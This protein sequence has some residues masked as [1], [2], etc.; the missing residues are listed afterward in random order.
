MAIQQ[1]QGHWRIKVAAGEF[2]P[3]DLQT[4]QDWV[5]QGRITPNDFVLSPVTNA[6][7][8]AMNVPEL[9]GLF[10]PG[11]PRGPFPPAPVKEKKGLNVGCIIAAAVA[12]FLALIFLA[13]MLVPALA[14]AREQARRAA[15]LSNLKQQ[16]LGLKQYAQDFSQMYPWCAGRQDPDEAWRDLGLMYPNYITAVGVYICPSSKDGR[17]EPMCDSGAKENYP[18][19]PFRSHPGECTS[20]A[21]S[22]ARGRRRVRPCGEED[23]STVRLLA[24]KKAGTEIGSANNDPTKANHKDD[25]RNVLYQDGH[26]KWQRGPDALDPDPE[27]DRIGWPS[28][29]DYADWW[30]DPPYYGERQQR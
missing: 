10:P 18:F 30:S 17:F 13:G 27:D 16:G 6:W 5:R 15:C 24:D 29:R 23:P 2:G 12:G 26:V 25:G 19:E 28:A 21:Y 4:V 1:P 11:M 9:M 8:P 3:V 22:Y 20:Y 14:R 7:V